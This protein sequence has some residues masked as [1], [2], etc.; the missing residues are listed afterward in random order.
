MKNCFLQMIT[1]LLLLHL[2]SVRNVSAQSSGNVGGISWE[3]YGDGFLTIGGTTDIFMNFLDNSNFDHI[4]NQIHHVVVEQ[5]VT[6]I[7]TFAFQSNFI[8]TITLPVTFSTFSAQSF[9]NCTA[10]HSINVV[11]GNPFFYS[12][13]GVIFSKLNAMLVMC[14]PGRTGAYYVPDTVET[15][16]RYAFRKCSK[17]TSIILPPSVKIINDDAFQNSGIITVTLPASLSSIGNGAFTMCSK[18]T[19]VNIPASVSFIGDAAFRFCDNLTSISVDTG[20]PVYSSIDRTPVRRNAVLP[21]IK[22]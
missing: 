16:E 20:N 5:G 18:L 9:E 14:P 1:L 6:S 8:E 10:L 2:T 19:T 13:D 4:R 12:D 7:G 22:K 21:S 15:I 17:L 11:A 3:F